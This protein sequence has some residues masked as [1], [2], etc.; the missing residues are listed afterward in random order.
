MCRKR[1][2]SRDKHND[3]IFI[4]KKLRRQYH[5]DALIY[6]LCKDVSFVAK[7]AISNAARFWWFVPHDGSSDAQ[8]GDDSVWIECE[9]WVELCF[10]DISPW[11]MIEFS[12]EFVLEFVCVKCFF[13]FTAPH[14]CTQNL[15]T[16]S[17][18]IDHTSP[19][20]I[21]GIQEGATVYWFQ[22]TRM[23]FLFVAWILMVA[24]MVTMFVLLATVG[25]DLTLSQSVGLWCTLGWTTAVVIVGFCYFMLRGPSTRV[26]PLP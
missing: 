5:P 8:K 2:L 22:T 10:D 26:A 24:I 11:L 17:Y 3:D 20:M 7:S 9:W 23:C 21:C 15:G 1:S 4:G 12:F 14:L 6:I 18:W 16:A 19:A 25:K 13:A